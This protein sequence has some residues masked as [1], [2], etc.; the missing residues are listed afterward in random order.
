MRP[1]LFALAITA[2]VAAHAADMKS[3]RFYEDALSRYEKHDYAGAVV[4]LKN[5]LKTDKTQLPVHVLLGKA[6]LANGDVVGAQVALEEALRLGVNRA[7]VVT[8]LARAL[9]NQG[10]SQDVLAD[11]RFSVAGLPGPTA[12]ELQILRAGAA[13]DV[14][15]LRAALKAGEDARAIDATDPAA[16]LVDVPLRLRLREFDKALAAADKALSLAPRN[17]D[18]YYSRGEV[19]HVSGRAKDALAAYEKTLALAPTHV[20]ALI[21]RA[22]IAMDQNRTADA[23]R[24]ARRIVELSPRDPRGQYLSALIAE[25]EGRPQQARDALNDVTA[26][27]DP[28]PIEFLRYRPQLL[29]LGGMAHQGLKQGEKAKPYFEAVLRVQPQHPVSKVLAQLHLDDRNIDRAVEVLETYLRGSPT[30]TQAM[31]QLAAAQMALGRHARAAQ[32]LQDALKQGDDPQLRSAYGLALVGRGQF[33]GAITELEAAYA[34][35]PRQLAAGFTLAALYLKASQPRQALKVAE[36]LATRYPDNASVWH[37]LGQARRQAGQAA[38]ARTAFEQGLKLD[39]AF[40]PAQIGLARLDVDSR[41]YPQALN[42]LAATLQKEPRNLEAL[43]VQAEASEAAG[44]LDKAQR[45]LE[46]AD[47]FAGRQNLEPGIALVEFHLRHSRPE[48]AR[49]AVG[50]LANKNPESVQTLVAQ[51]QVALASNDAPGARTPLTRAANTSGT[52]PP[53]LT[54]IALLQ[55]QAGDLKGASYS[56]DK[57]LGERPDYLPALALRGDLD[58][59][60]GEFSKAEALARQLIQRHPK[61]GLGHGMLGDL[62]LAR[63]QRDAAIAAYRRSHELA[64]SSDSLLRLFRT[65][66]GGDA[67]GAIRLA[68]QWLKTNPRD[69][70]VHRGLADAYLSTGQHDAA[71]TQYEALLKLTPNDAEALNNLA[72]TLVQLKDPG[73][74]AVA[75]RALAASPNA[76]HVIGTAGWAA[77]HAGKTERAVQLLRDARLRDPANPDT[78][79]FLASALA[80]VGRQAEAREELSFALKTQGPFTNRA[81]AQQ[82]LATLK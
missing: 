55:A 69:S 24:D 68:Q 12:F 30:D 77:L 4:Q 19:L 36:T 50:R 27:L 47:D 20:E 43:L 14:G 3:A 72:Y 75:E 9:I 65:Q 81:A 45:A 71:R 66:F 1:A 52:N 34:K 49:Q 13:A 2:A 6:L 56:V 63:N 33:G 17:P 26:L 61:L 70:L 57:A 10:K 64:P 31:L 67:P 15:D 42:R 54:R 38:G 7:E 32:I 16:W 46:V 29:M 59:R 41:A 35:D 8:P 51:A 28:V 39:P 82:L 11:P 40:A 58:I 48:A 73:A 62:A 25:R 18:A 23:A 53:L 76:A 79:Y 22:G 80:G 74:L 78:R 5:A 21:A 44:Q 37:L 60:A